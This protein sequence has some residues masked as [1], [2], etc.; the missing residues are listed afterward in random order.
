MRRRAL[1]Y[2]LLALTYLLGLMKRAILMRKRSYWI[3]SMLQSCKKE[4]EFF[5]LWPRLRNEPE[6]FFAYSRMN[7]ESFDLLVSKIRPRWLLNQL[8]YFPNSIEKK[9]HRA[10]SPEERLIIT[11][12]Y[13]ATG[14]QYR[15]MEFHFRRSF[16]TISLIVK[17]TC[18]AIWELH[19]YYLQLP[20]NNDWLEIANGFWNSME[21]SELYW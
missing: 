10:I 8:I 20:Q 5:T 16:S 19:Q 6:K 4:G 14:V 15:A 13:L 21:S 3:H 12:R 17:E 1:K 18:E 11:I 9:S 7:I 2:T